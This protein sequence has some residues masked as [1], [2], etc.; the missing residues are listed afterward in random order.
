MK[1]SPSQMAA[2]LT[3]YVDELIEARARGNLLAV[4]G[5]TQMILTVLGKLRAAQS[6]RPLSPRLIESIRNDE[7]R[8][9][10]ELPK[11]SANYINHCWDCAQRRGITV[12]VDKR[13]D[14][15]AQTG[16]GLIPWQ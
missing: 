15:V 8:A 1:D 16:T 14:T 9:E 10:L 6:S 2:R 11:T 4:R 7:D 13:V 12:L 5:R 3:E